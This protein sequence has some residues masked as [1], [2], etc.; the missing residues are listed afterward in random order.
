MVRRVITTGVGFV[1]VGFQ[2]DMDRS[3]EVSAKLADIQAQLDYIRRIASEAADGDIREDDPQ[4]EELMLSMKAL[5][6]QPMIT[7]REV[8]FL[9]FPE[10]NSIIVDPM[11]RQLRGFVGASWVAHKMFLTRMRSRRYTTSISIANIVSMI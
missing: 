11:C 2:R 6:D 9:I 10:S 1:K 5:M 7:I 8:L 3:P 4:I